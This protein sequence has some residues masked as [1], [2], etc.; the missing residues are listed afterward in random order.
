MKKL[1]LIISYLSI[2]LNAYQYLLWFYICTKI[3]DSRINETYD[4]YTLQ[5]DM[6]VYVIFQLILPII[7][8]YILLIKFKE[9]YIL[10]TLLIIFTF[11][12][13]WSVM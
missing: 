3:E 11:M 1:I 7:L 2:L 4:R 8:V 9:R 5:L 12:N 6:I 13:A 10:I